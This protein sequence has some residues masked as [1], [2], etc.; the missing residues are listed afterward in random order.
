MGEEIW[1]IVFTLWLVRTFLRIISRL[2]TTAKRLQSISEAVMER[3]GAADKGS[4]CSQGTE[5]LTA[6]V[7]NT[8]KSMGKVDVME[9]QEKM[10]PLVEETS[11]DEEEE[12]ET[13]PLGQ[14][15]PFPH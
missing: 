3:Q 2:T 6:N 14:S 12:D 9:P 13:E 5:G 8:H 15:Q 11:F 4:M 1:Q 7:P 10:W